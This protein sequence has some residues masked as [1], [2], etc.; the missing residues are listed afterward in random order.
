MQCQQKHAHLIPQYN[1]L[2]QD[3]YTSVAELLLDPT[4]F[5]ID[6]PA[7]GPALDASQHLANRS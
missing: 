4:C 5:A 7:P 1:L 6:R 2:S 3:T